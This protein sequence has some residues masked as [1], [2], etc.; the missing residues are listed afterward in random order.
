MTSPRPPLF[1]RNEFALAIV[2]GLLILAFVHTSRRSGLSSQEVKHPQDRSM[3]DPGQADTTKINN[4]KIFL[5]SAVGAYIILYLFNCVRPSSAASL[6][7]GS[8]AA[9]KTRDAMMGL[10]THAANNMTSLAS[11]EALMGDA[12]ETVLRNI[13]MGEPTF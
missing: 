3:D 6:F 11:D 5:G 8:G 12:I 13:D 4:I 9:Q 10:Q 7:G 2:V 1:L